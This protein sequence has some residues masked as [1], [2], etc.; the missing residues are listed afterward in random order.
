M[1]DIHPILG[2][3]MWGWT[4]DKA[5]CFELLSYFYD[6]GGREI[7]TATNYP[8]NKRP[9]DFRLAERIIQ[10]W[11]E[12]HGATELKVMMK[13]G[14][15]NNMRSPDNNLTKSFLLIL[16]DE[17]A[18]I[19]ED[20]LG[21]FMIHW[22][23]REAEED[24]RASLEAMESAR[25]AGLK[26]GLSGIKHPRVYA[27][28]NN[29]FS[30]DFRIQ[31]KH[32]IL[33]SDYSRYQPFHGKRRFITYG[34]NAGGIKLQQSDYHSGSSLKARGGDTSQ[35]HPISTA[36]Q[37]IIEEVNQ[38]DDRP[39]INSFNQCGMAFAYHS[40]DIESILLGTSRLSQL[41]ESL[42]FFRQLATYSYRDLYE[43]LK[44]LNDKAD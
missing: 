36:A 27:Q 22:D 20:N 43:K 31:I 25:S 5:T 17:Y 41:K 10:E 11:I 28:L 23:N 3:A 15:L 32:N 24:I 42:D 12:A 18:H 13:V 2:T 14:S 7:D 19:F 9:E 34:I 39:A 8:I 29:S 26:I 35:P 21:T 37:K 40:P 44:G 30:L 38:P 33:Y 6:N 16:L 1:N 4:I